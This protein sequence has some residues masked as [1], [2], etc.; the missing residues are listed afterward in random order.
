MFHAIVF[1]F[2]QLI[3]ITLKTEVDILRNGNA[4][5]T[6]AIQIW[7]IGVF[8]EERN[9]GYAK[10]MF[11]FLEKTLELPTI[12]DIFKKLYVYDEESHFIFHFS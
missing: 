4:D 11:P 12:N 5:P 6:V 10:E 7:S 1:I 3:S 9:P 2:P 8:D